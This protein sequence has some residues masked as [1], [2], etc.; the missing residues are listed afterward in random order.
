V[1]C[2]TCTVAAPTANTANTG[3]NFGTWDTGHLTNTYASSTGSSS[4]LWIAGPESGP[5]FLANA[6][7]GTKTFS[8]D[9]GMVTNSMG[10][11]GTVQGPR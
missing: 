1:T 8:F 9:G 3:I 11:A 10:V 5:L 2:T 7:V 6:L 4:P